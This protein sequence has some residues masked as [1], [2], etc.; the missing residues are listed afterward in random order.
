MTDEFSADHTVF[1]FPIESVTKFE[2]KTKETG[3]WSEQ[4]NL[5]YLLHRNCVIP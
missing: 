5:E 4:T 2:L 1:C 3:G